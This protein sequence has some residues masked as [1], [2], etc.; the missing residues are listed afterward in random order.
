MNCKEIEYRCQNGLSMRFGRR[1]PF[2]LSNID[3]TSLQMQSATDTLARSV[4][5]VTTY[6]T[7]GAR[8]VVCEFTLVLREHQNEIL[9]E[10]LALFHPLNSGT[11]TVMTEGYDYEIDCYPSAVPTIKRDSSVPYVYTFSVDF[12]CDEPYFRQCGQLQYDLKIGFNYI[13]S[14]SV[15]DTPVTLYIPDCS[16][17]PSLQFQQI[18]TGKNG[19]VSVQAFDGSITI[20]MRTFKAVGKNSENLTKNIKANSDIEDCVLVYGEN[21]IVLTNT[22]TATLSWYNLVTGVI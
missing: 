22:P 8:T 9:Q 20:D 12:V 3:A 15:I 6:R 10:V 19:N 1:K 14:S 2:L 7:F 13:Y 16:N 18:S 4:G 21:R 11:L 17:A 5:Q